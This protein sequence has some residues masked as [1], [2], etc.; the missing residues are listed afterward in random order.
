MKIRD[1]WRR[2]R[3]YY[4]SW[5]HF[6]KMLVNPTKALVLPWVSGGRFKTNNGI[7]FDIPGDCW[8]VLPNFLR[9]AAIGAEPSIVDGIKRIKISG[10]TLDSPLD[11]REEGNFCRE[12]FVEDVYRIRD[13]DLTGKVVVDIGA[14]IGDSAIAFALK[15]AEVYALEPSRKF[16]GYLTANIAANNFVGR[17]HPFAIGLSNKTES[18]VF[19]GDGVEDDRLDLVEGLDFVLR[20]L[21]SDVEYLKLDC[22]GCEYYLLSDERFLAHLQPKRIAMEF[23]HGPQDLQGILE[24]AG[25]QVEVMDGHKQVGYIYA[26]YRRRKPLPL[27]GMAEPNTRK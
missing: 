26:E 7:A 1:Q 11:T 19:P 13:S 23:H 8:Y 21:P 12:I 24:K 18:I 10:I 3:L 16:L 2:L 15:G 20:E 4:K 22:E 5:P 9:L 6:K 14:Y 17:I 25:Y 27:D